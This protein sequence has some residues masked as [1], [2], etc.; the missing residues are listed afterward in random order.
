MKKIID[1]TKVL[2]F[3]ILPVL[4]LALVEKLFENISGETIVQLMI[5]G[6]IVIAIYLKKK[7]LKGGK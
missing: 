3:M 2:I 5:I 4:S 1:F 7:Y 6:S